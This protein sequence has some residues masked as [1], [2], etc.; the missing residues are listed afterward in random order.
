MLST[1]EEMIRRRVKNNNY[2]REIAILMKMYRGD[3]K[4]GGEPTESECGEKHQKNQKEKFLVKWYN[5]FD[6]F[7]EVMIVNSRPTL[8][9]EIK[10]FLLSATFQLAAPQFYNSFFH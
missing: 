9:F 3:Y 8:R 1:P 2:S 7:K 10:L 4:Y 6:L 5:I